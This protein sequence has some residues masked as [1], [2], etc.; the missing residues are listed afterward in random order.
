MTT[1][2]LLL[3]LAVLLEEKGFAFDL[4]RDVSLEKSALILHRQAEIDMTL[5][6]GIFAAESRGELYLCMFIGAY[7][8]GQHGHSFYRTNDPAEAYK[9]IKNRL[10]FTS[11]LWI[12]FLGEKMANED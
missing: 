3:Q 1:P 6:M 10:T 7:L 9:A 5:K 12:R 8:E 11:G 4:V 2:S